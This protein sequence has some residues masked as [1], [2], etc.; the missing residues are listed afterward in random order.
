MIATAEDYSNLEKL[1]EIE[2]TITNTINEVLLSG[3][4]EQ[5]D[6]SFLGRQLLT[7]EVY[8]YAREMRSAITAK[9][10]LLADIKGDRVQSSRIS[11]YVAKETT[12][13][14]SALPNY[15]MWDMP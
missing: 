2:E 6:R 13:M 8:L 12:R 7:E 10:F 4:V 15:L 11:D 3:D 14:V 5:R 1:Y 9:A